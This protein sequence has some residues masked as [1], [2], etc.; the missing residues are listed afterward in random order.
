M[1]SPTNDNPTQHSA[2]ST[3]NTRFPIPNSAL[4]IGAVLALSALLLFLA[5]QFRPSYAVTIGT[6]TDGPLYDGFWEPERTPGENPPYKTYRWSRGYGTITFQDA[7]HGSYQVVVTVNGARPPGIPPAHLEVKSRGTT[8]LD[9]DPAPALA[10]YTFTVPSNLVADGA[11]LLEVTTNPFSPPGDPRELGLVFVGIAV[12]PLQSEAIQIPPASMWLAILGT[13]F[14]ISIFLTIL[15]WGPGTIIL[16]GSSPAI[17]ASTL[18]IFN[19]LWLT[20]HRWYEV[21]LPVTLGGLVFA[22]I[23]WL[24]GGPILRR[25][26]APWSPLQRRTLLT[27][28]FAAFVVRLAGELHPLIFVYDIGYHVN[29]L[30]L[31]RGGQLVFSTQPAE[32]EALGGTFYLPTAHLTVLPIEWLL[33]GDTRMAIRVLLIATGT[34]GILPLFYLAKRLAHDARAGIIAALLYVTLPMAVLP[35]SWGIL[36]N[37]FGEFLALLAIAFLV[38]A[39]S[40]PSVARTP[41]GTHTSILHPRHAPFWILTALLTLALLGHPGVVFLVLPAAILIPLLWLLPTKDEGRRTKD[42]GRNEN[43]RSKIQNALFALASLG[44]ALLITYLVYYHNFTG[45]IATSIQ[46]LLSN[47]GSGEFKRVIGGSVEDNS[48]GLIQREVTSRNAW[49]LGGI[50]GFWREL[51]A[52]YRAWPTLAALLGFLALGSSKFKIPGS[53]DQKHSAFRIP[54]SALRRAALAL[55]LVVLLLAFVGWFFNVYVRY[56]LFALPLVSLGTGLLL[57]PL[58]RRTWLSLLLVACTLAAFLLWAFSLWGDRI[59]F[60]FK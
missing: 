32:S 46:S 33:G 15:G 21:W 13:C 28:A 35:Y 42:E 11:L 51:V 1:P 49:V 60:A 14:L 7:G 25:V 56:M 16:L 38:G 50:E 8:L 3:Q 48:L 12:T 36:P 44:M 59:N 29:R 22:L 45:Q 41:S 9:I 20:S 18:L 58:S 4:P 6:A 53:K 23:V 24:V 31:V 2:L 19:R 26:G 10:T 37:V 27:I 39:A 47:R 54:H 57:S 52:Y 5:Y 34:L 40:T 30:I 43:R 17:F 55:A